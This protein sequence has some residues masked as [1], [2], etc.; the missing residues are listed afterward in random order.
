MS[1]R[2]LGP[3]VYQTRLHHHQKFIMNII[4]KYYYYPN[5]AS[6]IDRVKWGNLE[7]MDNLEQLGPVVFAMVKLPNPTHHC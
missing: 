3:L 5:S 6:I 4:T 2:V 7:R 1:A